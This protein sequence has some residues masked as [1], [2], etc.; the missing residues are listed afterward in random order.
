MIFAAFTGE[1]KGLLGSRWLADHP[2]PQAPLPVAVINL[3]QLRPLYPLTILTTM[4]LDDSTLGQTVRDIAGPMGIEVR[5]DLEP[6]RGLLRRSD[7]WP[8][9]QKGVPAVSFI[10]GYDPGTE[11]ERRYREWYTTRY[12]LPQDDMTTPID[13]EAAGAFNRFFF[14]LTERVANADAPPQW[15]PDSPYRPRNAD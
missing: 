13:H 2:T 1:E 8:F 14:T 6:E 9:M 5:P 3:D 11:A 10:F 15:L 12:H 4:A 7:H